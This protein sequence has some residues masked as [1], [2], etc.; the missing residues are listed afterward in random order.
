M[1]YALGKSQYILRL[2]ARYPQG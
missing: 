1:A 2:S